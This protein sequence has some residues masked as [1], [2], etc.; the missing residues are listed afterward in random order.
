[1]GDTACETAQLIDICLQDPRLG[2]HLARLASCGW[3][4]DARPLAK[5]QVMAARVFSEI[6]KRS[7]IG[8]GVDVLILA[9]RPIRDER[10]PPGY[11]PD[12]CT[13]R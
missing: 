2:W 11:P 12:R 9:H 4:A 7:E 6:V 1:M 8:R 10:L 3:R 5:G 13:W